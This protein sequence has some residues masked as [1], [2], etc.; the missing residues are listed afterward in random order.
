M[1]AVPWTATRVQIKS[2]LVASD[3]LPAPNPSSRLA[4][5]DDGS[6]PKPVTPELVDRLRGELS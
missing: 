5:L 2:I 6:T 4:T 1:P 3:F